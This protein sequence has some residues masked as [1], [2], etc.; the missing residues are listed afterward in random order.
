MSIEQLYLFINCMISIDSTIAIHSIRFDLFFVVLFQIELPFSTG[1]LSPNKIWRVA[2]VCV[3]V[4]C[5][6]VQSSGRIRFSAH[7]FSIYTYFSLH[8]IP[9]VLFHGISVSVCFFFENM[10]LCLWLCEGVQCTKGNRGK[11]ASEIK[12]KSNNTNEIRF[13]VLLLLLSLKKCTM[14]SRCALY[15]IEFSM[16]FLS[17]FLFLFLFLFSFFYL[18]KSIVI[19]RRRR[20]KKT[21]K[22]FNVVLS[23]LRQDLL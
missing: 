4:F 21:R 22:T 19:M 9:Y 6:W 13:Y 23:S 1:R 2:F 16:F 8:I 10:T 14:F 18:S 15:W 17:L 5:Y 7:I 12:N 20:R 11:T 3:C